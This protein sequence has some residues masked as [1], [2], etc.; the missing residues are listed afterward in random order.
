MAFVMSLIYN[1][2]NSPKQIIYKLA[3][4]VFSIVKYKIGYPIRIG[5]F[6]DFLVFLL[7][8]LGLLLNTKN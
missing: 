8:L 5:I 3:Q 1:I 2:S 6:W 4:K 7:G